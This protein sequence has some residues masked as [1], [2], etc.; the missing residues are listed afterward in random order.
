MIEQWGKQCSEVGM[1]GND[2]VL[3]FGMENEEQ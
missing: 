3:A 2:V 1:M